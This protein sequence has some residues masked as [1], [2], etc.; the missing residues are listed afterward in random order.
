M[1]GRMMRIRQTGVKGRNH[2]DTYIHIH[3]PTYIHTYIHTHMYGR[4]MR[5]RQT[6]SYTHIHVHTYTHICIRG[7]MT[8][9]RQ[10]G[11]KG[12]NHPD[13]KCRLTQVFPRIHTYIHTY[14]HTY[15]HTYTHTYIHIFTLTSHS[16]FQI[17]F[18]HNHPD[19][20]C[21]LTQVFDTFIHTYIHTIHSC[22]HVSLHIDEPF[23]FP[24]NV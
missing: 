19:F 3:I 21:R 12:Q 1:Y 9:M 18:R 6:P 7:R 2:P 10:R 23:T 13:F 11:V 5:M 22:M 4:M 16:H 15:I 24:N 17:L 8:R 14:M 20:K